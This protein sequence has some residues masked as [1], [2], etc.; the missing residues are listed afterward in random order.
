MTV[1]AANL[2][3][4]GRLRMRLT[5]WDD[6]DAALDGLKERFRSNSARPGVLAK[7]SAIDKLHS[8]RGGNV[9]WLANAIIDAMDEIEQAQSAGVTLDAA[10]V[11][12]TVSRRKRWLYPGSNRCASFASKYCHFFVVG[13]DFL[14][15]DSFALAAVNDLLGAKQY[16]L[17]PHRSEYRD[18]CERVHRLIERD[19]LEGVPVRSLDRY[20]WLWGQWLAQANHAEPQ[21]NRDVYDLFMS[22]DPGTLADVRLLAP[23]A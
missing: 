16:A 5:G 17:T 14:I 13:W 4:A 20:L 21:V 15:F 7:A 18:F 9:Y 23:S 2:D 22:D 11:V 10:D 1:T 8:T 3:A 6:A 19:N 12:N